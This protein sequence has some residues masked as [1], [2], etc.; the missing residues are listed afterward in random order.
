MSANDTEEYVRTKIQPQHQDSVRVLRELMR[1][2]APGATETI[3]YGSLAWKTR[4]VVAIISQSKTHLTFA[5]SRGAEFEDPHG[6]LKGEGKTTRHVKIKTPDG[7]NRDA[8]RDY[9]AQAMKLGE[10]G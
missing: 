4:K 10:T 6:L 2:S 8:L 9:I 1:E 3:S 5:F 7:I